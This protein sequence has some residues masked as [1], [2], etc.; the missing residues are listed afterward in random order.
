MEQSNTDTSCL[1]VP[2]LALRSVFSLYVSSYG[3]TCHATCFASLPFKIYFLEIPL[4]HKPQHK[5]QQLKFTQCVFA[6]GNIQ[7]SL[8]PAP[9]LFLHLL[10]LSLVAQQ[11][12]TMCFRVKFYPSEPMKIKEELTRYNHRWVGGVGEKTGERKR[13]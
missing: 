13:V 11:P 8:L 10:L 9:A 12:F 7:N 1:P 2:G 4:S 3:H 5:V 6:V